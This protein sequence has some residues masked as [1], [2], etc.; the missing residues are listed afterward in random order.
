MLEWVH[1]PIQDE[2]APTVA[3]IEQ[4]MAIV[5][6]AESEGMVC[7]LHVASSV[8]IKNVVFVI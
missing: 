7:C 3:Q 6:K 1:I 5:D 8:V 2:T 4:F